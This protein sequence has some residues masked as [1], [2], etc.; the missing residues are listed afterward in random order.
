[1]TV[2]KVTQP[3][4]SAARGAFVGPD[5]VWAAKTYPPTAEKRASDKAERDKRYETIVSATF[6]GEPQNTTK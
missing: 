5:S 4:V 1:M 2:R 6:I 3:Q